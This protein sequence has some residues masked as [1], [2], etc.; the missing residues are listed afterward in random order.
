[1]H[2]KVAH[3]NLSDELLSPKKTGSNGTLEGQ[4]LIEEGKVWDRGEPAG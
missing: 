1:M 4:V 2:S 3:I